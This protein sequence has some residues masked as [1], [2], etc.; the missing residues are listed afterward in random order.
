MKLM[1]NKKWYIWL[2]EVSVTILLLV[3]I[4]SLLVVNFKTLPSS[5]VHQFFSRDDLKD[6][7]IGD[8][9]QEV[10]NHLY[11]AVQDIPNYRLYGQPLDYDDTVRIHD[12]VSYFCEVLTG[13]FITYLVGY[14]SRWWCLRSLALVSFYAVT[15][16]DDTAPEA[17][18]I[19]YYIQYEK[20]FYGK[21]KIDWEENNWNG[22]W[23]TKVTILTTLISFLS[24]Q[25]ETCKRNL[26]IEKTNTGEEH[27]TSSPPS[28]RSPQQSTNPL[29]SPFTNPLP[30]P[31]TNPLLSPP[32]SFLPLPQVLISTPAPKTQPTHSLPP[33]TG[34]PLT[35]LRDLLSTTRHSW[36]SSSHPPVPTPV[37]PS[38]S[39]HRWQIPTQVNLP[40][41]VPT[42]LPPLP[43]MGEFLLPPPA[44]VR[45]KKKEL[46]K[47]FKG[48]KKLFNAG[49]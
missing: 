3:D 7:M 41:T 36:Q 18:K 40:P 30:S 6:F 4:I 27:P 2:L 33:K 5:V 19:L 13:F 32:V 21:E 17:L 15:R 39:L 48:L 43:D 12:S 8:I 42:Q 49:E 44:G 22:F 34:P 31:S 35:P 47:T 26:S 11:K 20:P 16:L 38:P 37:L 14:F 10:F 24:Y 45:P 46:S 25:V 23:V 28:P 9:D 29:P 1:K